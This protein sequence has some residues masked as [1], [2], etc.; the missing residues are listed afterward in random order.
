MYQVLG[1]NRSRVEV[2]ARSRLGKFLRNKLVMPYGRMMSLRDVL[3]VEGRLYEVYV[4][5]VKKAPGEDIDRD[6]LEW[7]SKVG[8][9]KDYIDVEEEVEAEAAAA[10]GDI[11]F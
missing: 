7:Y 3:V 5:T 8:V 6:P 2:P 11:P 4:K 9:I 1:T 10:A